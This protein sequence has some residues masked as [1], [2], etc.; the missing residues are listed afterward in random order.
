MKNSNIDENIYSLS[1]DDKYNLLNT[2]SDL[3]CITE[4]E[5]KILNILSND[6]GDEIRTQV[7]SIL[8]NTDSIEAENILIRLLQD[9]SGLVR[10]SAC[11]SL[12]FSSSLEVLYLLMDIIKKDT[13]DLVRGDAAISI[14]SILVNINKIEKEY[15][16]FFEDI[17]KKEKVKWVKLN[18]YQS[19]YFLGKKDY[20]YKLI[21][22]LNNKHFRKRALVV[23][24]LYGIVTDENRKIIRSSIE[25][26]LKKEDTILVKSIIETTLKD[27]DDDNIEL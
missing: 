18:I 23:N 26:L 12:R 25:G 10:A 13:T 14:A 5:I 11:D 7:A 3:D 17:L 8:E 20:L 16:D 22:E 4:K 21:D 9:P 6:K 15:V 19:L 24:L 1:S 27:I 2:I